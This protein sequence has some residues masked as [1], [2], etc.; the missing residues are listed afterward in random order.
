MSSIATAYICEEDALED[1]VR[2]LRRLKRSEPVKRRVIEFL[3]EA[4]MSEGKLEYEFLIITGLSHLL[5]SNQGGTDPVPLLKEALRKLRRD[6]TIL[7]PVN[8]LRW[9]PTRRHE[10][11]VDDRT[12]KISE[13]DY[14]TTM[15]LQTEHVRTGRG[16]SNRRDNFVIARL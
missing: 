10:I 3:R 12:I 4:Y 1:L 8:R 15:N 13:I 5:A 11:T 16:R 2:L 9:A 7:I 6:A 14:E